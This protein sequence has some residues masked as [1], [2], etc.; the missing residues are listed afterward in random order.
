VVLK[1]DVGGLL[2]VAEWMD[3]EMAT[4]KFSSVEGSSEG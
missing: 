2:G 4:L 3:V 1:G